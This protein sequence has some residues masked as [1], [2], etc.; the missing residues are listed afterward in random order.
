MAAYRNVSL[1]VS[2]GRCQSSSCSTNAI[3]DCRVEF[4]GWFAKRREPCRWN[5]ANGPGLRLRPARIWRRVDYKLALFVVV[6]VEELT[7]PA[8]EGPRMAE[9]SPADTQLI[10]V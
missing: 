6:Q 1:T 10:L 7:L 3:F 5:E 8:P 4:A 2:E 9:T